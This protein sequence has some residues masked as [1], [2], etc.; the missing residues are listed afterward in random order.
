MKKVLIAVLVIMTV[1]CASVFA[2]EGYEDYTGI[3]FGI[4]YSGASYKY[5]G[6]EHKETCNPLTITASE[7][8]FFQG[9]PVGIYGDISLV[10][11]LKFKKDDVESDD[12]H[13]AVF[14]AVGPAFRIYTGNKLS[15]LLGAGFHFYSTSY[16]TNYDYWKEVRTY[17]GAGVELYSSYRFSKNF[18]FNGGV[19]AS[20]FFANYGRHTDRNYPSYEISY[21]SFAEIRVVPKLGFYYVY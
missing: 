16:S 20:F 2:A 11:P 4:G 14:A 12:W 13:P 18:A 19:T 3:T 9:S 10:I 7:Y 5:L 6:L 21:D 1:F 8:A 15:V 17:Y